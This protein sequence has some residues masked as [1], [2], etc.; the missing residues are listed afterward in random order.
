MFKLPQHRQI[1]D[2]I[3]KNTDK[4]TRAFEARNLNEARR[5]AKNKR[6]A[7]FANNRSN[8]NSADVDSI[9]PRHQKMMAP[10]RD[11]QYLNEQDR[12]LKS[13]L[14]PEDSDE[15]KLALH[16]Q[17]QKVNDVNAKRIRLSDAMS[18]GA[19]DEIR[20]DFLRAHNGERVLPRDK[21]AVFE[22]SK[23]VAQNRFG[24]MNSKEAV[25]KQATK[26][27]L[28]KFM[29]Q[30]A[31]AQ[32]QAQSRNFYQPRNQGGQAISNFAKQRNAGRAVRQAARFPG[33][34]I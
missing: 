32:Q 10:A 33:R 15:L 3:I 25:G 20:Y 12:I 2:D 31:Q 6:L 9:L 4:A 26:A 23:R 29:H 14:R 30:E 28:Q 17:Q 21:N 22:R 11:P 5:D 8:M 7:E 18:G 24:A 1:S 16:K 19:L 13:S 27:E 34:K